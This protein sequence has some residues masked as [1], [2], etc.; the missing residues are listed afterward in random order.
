MKKAPF[1]LIVLLT[2]FII[3][4]TEVMSQPSATLKV[5]DMPAFPSMPNDSVYEGQ[6]Y[7]FSIVI[8]NGSN[9][10]IASSIE[11]VLKVDS[12]EDVIYTNP[13][14]TVFPG[15]TFSVSINSYLFTQPQFQA[16]NNIVVVCPRVIGGI[17]V[18]A[19]SFYADVYFIPISSLDDGLQTDNNM[20]FNPFPVPSSDY[21][22]FTGIEDKLFEYVRIYSINGQLVNEYLKPGFRRL[23]IGNLPCGTYIMEAEIDGERFRSKFIRQ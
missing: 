13:Q 20:K 12:L 4:R 18:P 15:D 11:V 16:G 19:D 10:T 7:G 21:I 6:P 8:T 2:G 23:F 5:I 14:T 22:S 9:I 17:V 1:L 3:P